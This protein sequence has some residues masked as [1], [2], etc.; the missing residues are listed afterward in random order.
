MGGA[1]R[2]RIP[3][4]GAERA[5]AERESGARPRGARWAARSQPTGATAAADSV[6]RTISPRALLGTVRPHRHHVLRVHY[7]CPCPAISI[8]CLAGHALRMATSPTTSDAPSRRTIQYAT[9]THA[10]SNRA[11]HASRRPLRRA[12]GGRARR[13]SGD[14]RDGGG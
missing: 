7:P 13:A 6:S 1:E 12:P 14:G 9:S 4:L 2:M 8:S 3:E 11:R 5:G 10:S